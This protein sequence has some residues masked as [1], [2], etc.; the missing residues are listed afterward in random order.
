MLRSDHVLVRPRSVRPAHG[1]HEDGVQVWPRRRPVHCGRRH[2]RRLCVAA[3]A[4]HATCAPAATT[5]ALPDSSSAAGLLHRPGLPLRE[6]R[7]LRRW[8][9][10]RR[11]LGVRLRNGLHR[12]RRS[13]ADADVRARGLVRRHRPCGRQH[14]VKPARPGWGGGRGRYRARLRLWECAWD[15]KARRDE[16]RYRHDPVPLGRHRHD[17]GRHRGGF[18]GQ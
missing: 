6:R 5:G 12:L 8:R 11:V 13:C 18:L 15:R 9:A 1:Q 16:H 4:A 17:H 10:G 7:R 14:L 2:R 3:H